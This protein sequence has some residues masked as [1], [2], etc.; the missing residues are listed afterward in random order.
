MAVIRAEDVDAQVTPLALGRTDSAP[1]VAAPWALPQVTSV[2]SVIEA[3]PE[4]VPEVVAAPPEPPP[5]PVFEVPG[6]VLQGVYD[7]AVLQGLEEGKAQVFSELQILQQRYAGALD[8]LVA[9]SRE[10]AVNNQLQLITLACRVAEKLVRQQLSVRPEQLMALITDALAD[11]GETDEVTVLCS[12]P[13]HEFIREHRAELTPAGAAFAVKVTAD[14]ALE[15]GDF[16][17]ETHIGSIDGRVGTQI[18]AVEGQL[19]EDHQAAAAQAE[20]EGE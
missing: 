14:P 7:Q 9:V 3:E 8:Q 13:D 6:E 4:P 5:P 1:C 10:L 20:P 18:A 16:R 12:T 19:V 15:Y 11:V 17:V 2:G